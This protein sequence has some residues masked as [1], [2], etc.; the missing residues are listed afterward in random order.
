[1]GRRT[2]KRVLVGNRGEIAV[3]IIR[4]CRELGLKTVA[5]YS[6]ADAE[7]LAV[8]LADDGICIGPAS[9]SSSYLDAS[10]L[11][12][13]ALACEAQAIH[14]GYGFLSENAGFAELCDKQGITFVGPSA[15]VITMMGDKIEARRV[16]K[17]AGVPT[18]PGS[19]G[20][21]SDRAEA[22]EVAKRIGFP[23]LL[24]AAA[25][26]GGRGMRVVRA[27]DELP[28]LLDEAM[29]EALAAFG[30]GSVYVERY[31]TNVRHVE[32]QVLGDGHSVIHLG[33]RDC[34]SQR[35][36]QKLVEE[37]PSPALDA[38]QRQDLCGSAVRLCEHVGYSSAGTVEYILDLDSGNFYFMEMNTRIQVE[39]P[40]T[41]MVTGI[42]LV[43]EQ[44]LIA[45]GVPLR[46]RQQDVSF[47]GHAIE[48]RI[49]AED[50]SSGFAPSPGRISLYQP[51]GGPGVRVDSH[52]RS[53]YEVPPFYDSLL[54]K[55]ICWGA[56]R[57]E[58]LSRMDGALAELQIEG[59][60][61]TT[62]F[63]RHLLAQDAFRA[64]TINT[65]YVHD[66][67]GF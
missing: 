10:R 67:L 34:S 29:G 59:V 2:V 8:Q 62:S 23:V 36:N 61:T 55:L 13:A 53:G 57:N 26:G 50:P 5:A 27:A 51:P 9:A 25:G 56:D 28:R 64:G 65:R 43:K 46:L 45:C 35:R 3:R 60:A 49:N 47:R 4:A 14:P 22:I 11:V 18:T 39:H 31:L 7:S 41:E 24:K 44:L 30:N 19:D 48:C 54:L 21:V 17:Q 6:Q 37:S 32:V 40:V 58:A 15:K 12:A 52:L 1:M 20:A 42:D 38:A 66:V 63:Q 16:A 33:E